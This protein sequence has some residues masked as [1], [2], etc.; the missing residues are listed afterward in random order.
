MSNPFELDR[1]PEYTEEAILAEI[2]RV[3]GLIAEDVITQREFRKHA[4]VGMNTLRRRFGSFEKALVTA[5]L[6]HR[7][8]VHRMS[9]RQRKRPVTGVSDAQL[10]DELRSVARKLG[11]PTVTKRD[12]NRL[13][14]FHA[15]A[16]R[17]R[18]GTWRAALEKAGLQ[19]SRLGKRYNDDECF[20]NLLQVWTY[21]GRP[22]RHEE[23]SRPP[24]A[25]GPK[26]YVKRWGTW[27]KALSAF[28]ERVNKD[29]EALAEGPPS[30]T[31]HEEQR[32]TRDADKRDIP[33]GLRY[34]VLRRDNFKCVICGASPATDPKC[35]LHV[36]HILPWSRGGKTVIENLRTLCEDCNLG[37]GRKIETQ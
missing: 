27:K 34:N 15:E 31:K 24:S 20:E 5:G 9:S 36:D 1:L 28:V 6:A 13:S 37:K 10:L 8:N 4:R 35:R 23:M 7:F 25:V 19:I 22:P 12:F 26:A 18:F 11:R 17:D 2:K 33:L 30:T 21:Y 29:A 32:P 16:I 3:A 14:E